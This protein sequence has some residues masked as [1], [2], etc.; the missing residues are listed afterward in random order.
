MLVTAR[1]TDEGGG[2]ARVSI[3]PAKTGNQLFAWGAGGRITNKF[4]A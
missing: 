1:V 4:F 3:R 2:R